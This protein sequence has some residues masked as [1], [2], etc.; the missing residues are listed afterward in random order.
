MADAEHLGVFENSIALC[1]Y[2]NSHKKQPS[3]DDEKS[4]DKKDEEEEEEKD[5]RT[6]R[7]NK[8]IESIK[9]TTEDAKLYSS[10][11]NKFQRVCA[12]ATNYA[13]FLAAARGSVGT[14]CWMEA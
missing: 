13:R 11:S 5:P 1:N 2:E 4:E 9:L 7:I 6:E 3:K 10:D 14:P 8:H 12:D